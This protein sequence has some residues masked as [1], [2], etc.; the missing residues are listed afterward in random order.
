MVYKDNVN[1]DGRIEKVGD[2]FYRKNASSWMTPG[3][4]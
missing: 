3:I 4:L 1:Q 2:F